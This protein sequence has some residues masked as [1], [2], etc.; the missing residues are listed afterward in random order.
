MGQ[1]KK[2][3]AKE[4]HP[5]NRS[6][7]RKWLNRNHQK[8][9]S[10]WL[11]IDKKSTENPNLSWSEAVDEALC[12]GW[13]DSVKRPIDENSYK[14]YFSPRKA[15]GNWSRINKEKVDELLKAGLMSE[16]GL[17][18]IRIA[19]ANGSWSRLDDIENL[20]VPVDLENELN[21]N[22]KAGRHY[23]SL[24][25]SK[26][27]QVLYW[28]ASAKTEKTRIKRLKELTASF[29]KEQLPSAIS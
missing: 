3:E 7:W 26:K 5:K 22:S 19:K 14:Q 21:L 10:I 9:K 29:N 24:S 8:S 6:A 15:D 27:K 28:L 4:F 16:A 2:D 11:V 17:D 25:A 13:I 20:V 18:A 1:N 23:A 12:F